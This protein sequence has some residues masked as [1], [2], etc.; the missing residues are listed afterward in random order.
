MKYARDDIG[1]AFALNVSGW[2]TLPGVITTTDAAVV[3]V[4]HVWASC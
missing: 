3:G 2:S 1:E 4:N